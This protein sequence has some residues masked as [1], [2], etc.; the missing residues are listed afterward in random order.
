MSFEI[1]CQSRTSGYSADLPNRKSE[2]RFLIVSPLSSSLKK[3]DFIIFEFKLIRLDNIQDYLKEMDFI[4]FLGC[5]LD[6]VSVTECDRQ[7]NLRRRHH[8]TGYLSEMV[9]RN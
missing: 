8:R 5:E 4:W 7:R 2:L 3:L 1:L 6:F 9:P